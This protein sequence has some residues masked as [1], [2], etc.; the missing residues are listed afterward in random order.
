MQIARKSIT[1][2]YKLVLGGVFALCIIAGLIAGNVLKANHQSSS[3]ASSNI[4]VTDNYQVSIVERSGGDQALTRTSTVTVKDSTASYGY[5]LTARIANNTVPGGTATIGSASSTTCP[6]ATP[7]ALPSDNASIPI[8]STDNN[9]AVQANGDAVE[10]EVKIVIPAS[11]ALGNYMLDIEYDEYRNPDLTTISIMQE[12]TPKLCISSAPG[13]MVNLRDN[14]D[15]KV[16]RVKRM[17]D[18]RC[19][20]VDNLA[21]DVASAAGRPVYNPAVQLLSGT[22]TSV[23]TQAQYV[24]NTGYN[25]AAG[26]TT[27]LYNWCAAMAD[28]STGC[29]TT[30]GYTGGLPTSPQ[31]GICPAPFRLPITTYGND[32]EFIKLDIAMGGTGASR[33]NA[34][35]Y[36][37][38]LGTGTD[39]TN[40]L[41][42]MGGLYRSGL[43]NRGTLGSW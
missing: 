12:A 43:I 20:M 1:D 36:S 5:I 13:L 38:W 21:Y 25:T 4:T 10:W 32:N 8:I 27:Y 23:N 2:K 15:N 22:M 33:A 39:S 31:T 3:A 28:T 17:V 34:N 16:Y 18:G 19:W 35:T 30:V 7:C 26:Q 37:L 6:L 14:R 40:W 24:L 11:T 29:A 9:N 42:V 41:G